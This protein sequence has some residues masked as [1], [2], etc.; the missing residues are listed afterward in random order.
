MRTM[1]HEIDRKAL[2]LLNAMR[3]MDMD[4]R[5]NE[6]WDDARAHMCRAVK[7]MCPEYRQNRDLVMALAGAGG[8][9]GYAVAT[10]PQV[11]RQDREV[12]Q[13][14]LNCGVDLMEQDRAPFLEPFRDDKG[15]MLT[16]LY[17]NLIDYRA[18]SPGLQLDTDIAVASLDNDNP[19]TSLQALRPE[20]F[21]D[22]EFVL[23]ALDVYP[24]DKVE[25]FLSDQMCC[26]PDI[27]DILNDRGESL[28]DLIAGAQE[29]AEAGRGDSRSL[30][31]EDSA[32]R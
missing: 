2:N 4:A 28:D 18:V 21:S 30:G 9:S 27:A 31:R 23:C 11:L 19:E 32:S 10:M 6:T 26:D 7:K 3:A 12:A 16:A 24:P 20:V 15:M 22:K 5:G 1:Q 17:G 25:P 13:T 8:L 29:R 14:I